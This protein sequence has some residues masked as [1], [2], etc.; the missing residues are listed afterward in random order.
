[1]EIDERKVA[2]A[3]AVA[4]MAGIALLLFMSETP[5]KA[6]VAESLVAA[7]DS[8]L[9]ITGTVA[10]VSADKFQICDIVCI[11]VRNQGLPSAALLRNGG[12][13]VVLG[14]ANEYMGN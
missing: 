8:L 12:R 10:N 4:A 3:A 11:S 5:K 13:A 7:P 2:I 6:S 9:E 1:M 14:R